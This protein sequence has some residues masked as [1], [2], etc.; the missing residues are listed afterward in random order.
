M[1]ESLTCAGGG[2]FLLAVLFCILPEGFEL[3]QRA[4]VHAAFLRVQLGFDVLK[5]A[6]E[7]LACA[8]E[9]VFAV[10]FEVSCEVDEGEHEVAKFL[11]LGAWVVLFD[12][13]LQLTDFFED[14]VEDGLW[15][16]PVE[17]DLGD[18]LGDTLGEVQRGEDGGDAFEDGG[19]FVGGSVCVL[20]FLGFDPCPVALDLILFDRAGA[21]EDVGVAAQEFGADAV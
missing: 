14:F 4:F 11:F 5:A 1:F 18:F 16:G 20:F 19:G 8:Q 6:L 15:V 7:F 12:G 21:L 3:G 13:F 2:F 17:A 10:E 9:R